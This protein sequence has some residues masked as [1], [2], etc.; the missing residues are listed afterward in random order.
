MR[1]PSDRRSDARTKLRRLVATERRSQV[2]VVTEDDRAPADGGTNST[3]A[4]AVRHVDELDVRQS[5]R[6]LVL[7]D[8]GGYRDAICQPV[9]ALLREGSARRASGQTTRH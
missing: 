8:A 1:Q 9:D 4:E 7:R 5:A 3:I 6:G 2:V